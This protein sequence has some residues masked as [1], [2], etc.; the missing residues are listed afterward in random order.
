MPQSQSWK[1]IYDEEQVVGISFCC[2]LVPTK[3]RA[4]KL[5]VAAILLCRLLHVVHDDVV[6]RY[7]ATSYN[8]IAPFQGINIQHKSG[9]YAI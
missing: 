4:C 5:E 2:W 8:L 3:E 9:L 6:G 1:N 7:A